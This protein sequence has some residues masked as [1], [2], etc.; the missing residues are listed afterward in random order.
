MIWSLSAFDRRQRTGL[1]LAAPTAGFLVI[2]FVIPA[3]VLLV[4]SFWIS[5]SFQITPTLTLDNYLR[6]LGN[7]GVWL[8]MWNGI[9]IGLG[10][11]LFSVALSLPVSWY[12]PYPTRADALL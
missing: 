7:A 9:W 10:T 2:F 6:A 3:V 4:Y 11:A 8:S 12:I 1:A 5:R